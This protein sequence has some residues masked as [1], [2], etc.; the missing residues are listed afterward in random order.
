MGKAKLLRYGGL[1]AGA[2]L[3]AFGIGAIGL[4]INGGKTVRDNL[5]AEKITFG[6]AATDPTVPKKYS[7]QLVDNGAKAR[8][9]AKM[10]RHHTL[11]AT[12]GFTY[13]E[14]GR[15]VAKADAPKAQLA[16][17]GGTNSPIYA[18]VDSATNQPKANPNRDL[19]VTETAL[20]TALNTAYMAENLALFGL[21][22]GVALLLAG[23]GF[24]VL[25]WYALG[26]LRQE[27]A[28][29]ATGG[30]AAMKPATGH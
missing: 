19:W 30:A 29:D 14:I 20:S 7:N 2:I 10:M 26:A 4:S 27:T 9:F 22:V 25:A 6:D 11:T 8:E 28:T 12:G 21:V 18:A 16:A 15:Y 13:S 1:V 23:I 3:I 24:I 5:K 17:G